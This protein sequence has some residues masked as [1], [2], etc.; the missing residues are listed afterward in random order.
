[1]RRKRTPEARQAR[2]ELKQERRNAKEARSLLASFEPDGSPPPSVVPSGFVAIDWSSQE[3]R[4]ARQVMKTQA[5]G[6]LY[7]KPAAPV[8]LAT[9]GT[10]TGRMSSRAPNLQRM[11]R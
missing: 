2:K 5:F 1:M 3:A 9:Q 10:E 6:A 7:G 8:F 4:I 11:K